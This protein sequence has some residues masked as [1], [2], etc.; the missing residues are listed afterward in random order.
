M[1]V[2]MNKLAITYA[3]TMARIPLTDRKT[4]DVLKELRAFKSERLCSQHQ[5][6]KRRKKVPGAACPTKDPIFVLVILLWGINDNTSTTRIH[7]SHTCHS[8]RG[9]SGEVAQY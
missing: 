9:L 7:I 2:R 8:S 6:P 1:V 5:R 4:G 3:P